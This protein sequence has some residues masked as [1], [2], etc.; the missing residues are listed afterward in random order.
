[1]YNKYKPVKVITINKEQDYVK[2]S[3]P[4]L[5]GMKDRKVEEQINQQIRYLVG[6][7]VQEGS[8]P[9]VTTVDI[10]YKTEVNRNGVYSVKFILFYFIEH[11]AHPME[12]QKALTFSTLTGHHYL[13]GELFAPNSYYKT[14]LTKYVKEFVAK[15][16]IQLINEIQ[17]ITDQQEYYLTDLDLV[18]FYQLYEYTPYV[19]GFLEIPI[20]LCEVQSMSAEESPIKQ[21]TSRS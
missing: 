5:V 7:L 12:I 6:E 14:R 11:A 10:R 13:F 4:K 16:N 3:Y 15:E 1:M 18:L 20:P 2:L 17:T 8:Q 21:L 19:Y 9:N